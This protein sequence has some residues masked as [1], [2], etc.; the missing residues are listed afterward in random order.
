MACKT[1]PRDGR[2]NLIVAGREFDMTA[3]LSGPEKGWLIIHGGGAVSNEIKKRFVGLAGGPAANFVLIPT[4]MSEKKIIAE[5]LIR[6]QGRGWAQSWGINH[7]TMLHSRDRPR[8]N[9]E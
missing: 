6:G 5:G 9:S 4:A 2:P 7:V 8:A 1:D 3:Q